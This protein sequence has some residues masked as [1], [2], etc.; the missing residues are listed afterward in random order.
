MSQCINDVNSV[1]DENEK[2]NA[3]KNGGRKLC[4]RELKPS[5][6]DIK[7]GIYI[8]YIQSWK[9]KMTHSDFRPFVFFNKTPPP[10]IS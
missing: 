3:V 8:F 5:T 9:Q 4:C 1:T 6:V 10:K 2:T 7:G